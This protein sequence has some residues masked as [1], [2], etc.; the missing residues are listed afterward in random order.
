MS[1]LPAYWSKA[2]GKQS[3]VDAIKAG[4]WKVLIDGTLAESMVQHGP[5]ATLVG[6][7]KHG[8]KYFERKDAQIVRDRWVVYANATDFRKQEPTLVPAEWHGWLNHITDENP[9][10]SDFKHPIY[11]SEAVGNTTAT[12]ERYQPKGSWFNPEKRNWRKYQAW[13]PPGSA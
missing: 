5:G 4:G 8:N 9:S 1:K 3:L 2:L 11:F 13:S 7:D 12:P 6:V 10:N